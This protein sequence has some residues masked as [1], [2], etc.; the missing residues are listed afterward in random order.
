METQEK[1]CSCGGRLVSNDNTPQYILQCEKCKKIQ[2][3]PLYEIHT[4]DF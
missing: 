1:L 2:R 3:D 4:G